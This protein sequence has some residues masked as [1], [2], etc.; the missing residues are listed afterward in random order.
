MPPAAAHG[1][2]VKN[3]M[4][5]GTALMYWLGT[6]Q[7]HRLRASERTRLG[8]TF[9]LR[10]F[11]DRFLSFGAIPVALAARLTSGERAP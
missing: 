9:S 2:A 6:S 3:S 8:S 1:E 7:I 11:H 5:P 4:F 10:A